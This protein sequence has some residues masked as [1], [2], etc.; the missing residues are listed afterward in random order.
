MV[1]AVAPYQADCSTLPFGYVEE[2]IRVPTAGGILVCAETLR[3]QHQT[4]RRPAAFVFTIYADPRND[5]KR[6]EYAVDRGYVGVTAYTRGKACGNGAITPYEDDGRDADAVI[7]W[8]AK[9]PWSDGRVGMYGGSYNGF[10][11]WA[12]VKH[13][14]A[15]LK[16]IVPYVA[17]NP[18]DGLPMQ[19]NIFLLVNYAWIY[20]VTSNKYLDEKTYHSPRW[21]GLNERWYE[22]G[23]AY[24]D[25]DAIAGVANPWLHKW[26]AHPS[27][28]AYWQAMTPYRWEFANIRIPVLTV[29]GYYDDGQ[30]SAIRYFDDLNRFNPRADSYLVIGPWDHFGSQHRV[31]SPVLRGYRIDSVAQI[32]TPK[33]TFDWFDYVMRGKQRPPL[34]A[35]HVNYEVM[36]AN[37]WRHAATF[38]GTGREMRLYL[39]GSRQGPYR[40][41]STQPQRRVTLEQRVDFADRKT[42]NNDSYPAPI[43]G[44]KPN[45]SNGYVFVTAPFDKPADLTGFDASIDLIVNKRDLDIGLVLYELRADGTLMQLSYATQRASFAWNKSARRLLVPG[46]RTVVPIDEASFFSKWVAK[47]SR[48]MLTL[49]VN[50]NPYAEIN[51]GTGKNVA[52]E[53][54][55]DGAV[56]MRVQWLTDSFIRVRTS[57]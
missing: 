23:R 36:G 40:M 42:S 16:T 17:N 9:Q 48:L 31:K 26:L 46:Q 55:H 41:L 28:D 5:A 4:S 6:M 50:K 43:V 32:D 15:P 14:P 21:N 13:P 12:A 29:T 54:I 35:D 3:P 2:E 10:T 56:P 45:V 39:S 7:N 34:V 51:Y 49:N 44:K 57:P 53:T 19:N 11:Q 38:E 37:Q 8:I 24:R 27:Y 33:L 25:V 47:G 20:Y 22:S 52:A 18:G 30:L 1:L